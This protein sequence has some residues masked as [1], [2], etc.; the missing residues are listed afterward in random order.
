[1]RRV[2]VWFPPPPPPRTWPLLCHY[3]GWRWPLPCFCM[4]SSWNK[5]CLFLLFNYLCQWL[6]FVMEGWVPPGFYLRFKLFKPSPSQALLAQRTLFFVSRFLILGYNIF[7]QKFLFHFS[8]QHCPDH[9]VFNLMFF[10]WISF[11]RSPNNIIS[12][13]SLFLR[14]YSKI[15][16]AHSYCQQ[17]LQ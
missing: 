12:G 14:K 11:L 16:M 4:E 15:F 10:S 17:H 9:I 2:A 1:M 8:K 7:C 6:T 3:H 13:I 5:R